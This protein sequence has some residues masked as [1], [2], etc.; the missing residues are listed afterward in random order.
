MLKS[1]LIR[2]LHRFS[3]YIPLS[4]LQ[5]WSRQYFLPV[6]Y[7]TISDRPLPHI[8]HLYQVRDT[9]TFEADLDYFLQHY[10]PV[11][12][13]QV[14][15]Y[16]YEQQ[17][18]PP[19]AFFLTFDDGL[20]ECATIIAPILKRKG[21]P[22]AFFINSDFVDNKA[23]MFRYQASL[24]IEQL[25]KNTAAEQQ[26]VQQYLANHGRPFHGIKESLLAVRW[27]QRAVLAELAQAIGYSFEAFLATEQPYMT[28]AQ[29]QG[30]L[31]QGFH[32]GS[33]SQNHPTYNLLPLAQQLEQTIRGQQHL[34]QQ[35]KLPERLFA[36]PF[37]D[38][39]VSRA[40]F[41]SI[42]GQ[43]KF[44]LTF[45]GAGLKKETIQGQLQRFGVETS[46]MTPLP[47]TLHTEYC[48]YLLKSFFGKNT[49]HRI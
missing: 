36:F 44:R 21:I 2:G 7:H 33:H 14:L 47:T 37:T 40:F 22:A 30:L 1:A 32:I 48:Y 20:A 13:A 3:V 5:T 28:M 38:Y 45:G 49:L 15:A 46:T 23:L 26:L 10:T 4:W 34:E 41:E 9:A 12:V 18:L 35:L 8:R 6:F 29:I 39:G 42:L 27:P 24:L 31:D 16:V 25:A 11:N 19:R 43:A 17:P